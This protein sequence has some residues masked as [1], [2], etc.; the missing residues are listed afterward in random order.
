M[1]GIWMGLRRAIITD[2]TSSSYRA[3][4]GELK[5]SYQTKVAQEELEEHLHVSRS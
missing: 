4:Y 5:E 2:Q 1:L 3:A